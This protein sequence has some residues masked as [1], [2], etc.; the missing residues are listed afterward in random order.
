MYIFGALKRNFV[1]LFILILSNS[2]ASDPDLKVTLPN[3]LKNDTSR[4]GFYYREGFSNRIKNPQYSFDCAKQCEHFAI[5]SGSP[6]HVAQSQN[7]LGILYYRKHDFISALVYHKKALELRKGI[8]DKK[9]IALTL[10]NLGNIY[11]DMK[12]FVL[13]ENAYLEALNINNELGNPVQTGNCLVNLGVLN[14]EEKNSAVAKNYFLKAIRNAKNRHDYELEA[15]CQNNLAVI[16]IQLSEYD[17]AI[18]NCMNSIKAKELM[19]NEMEM[20][21]SYLNLALVYSKTKQQKLQE[22]SLNQAGRIID[23][24]NYIAA[25]PQFYL[26]KSEYYKSKNDLEKAFTWLSNYTKLSDSLY[27][28]N[29]DSYNENDF[30]ETYANN[31]EERSG[32]FTFV[33]LNVLII[34]SILTAVFVFRF[35]S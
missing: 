35:K 24:Y 4:A 20:A 2:F 11:C 5:K 13:A 8:A 32:P 33:I 28:L 29:S 6:F 30:T 21:D 3:Y 22:E 26:L 25:R 10:T 18:A 9:E 12:R 15:M 17:E 34:L 27:K 31:L 1:I 23:K 16:N 19:N 14:V 7:L